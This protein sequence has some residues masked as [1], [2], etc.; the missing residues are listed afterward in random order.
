MKHKRQM[1]VYALL[2]A[3]VLL[4]CLWNMEISGEAAKA[5]V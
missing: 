2:L 5:R 4:L 1:G 3:C